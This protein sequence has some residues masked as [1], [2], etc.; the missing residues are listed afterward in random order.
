MQ[1]RILIH[2]DSSHCNAKEAYFVQSH[3]KREA[4]EG[5]SKLEQLE[6]LHYEIPPTATWIPI[7]AI[8]VRSQG[9]TRQSENY[10]FEKNAK[11]SNFEIWQKKN[12]ICDTPSEADW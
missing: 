10:K 11:N 4:I 9:K 3:Y 7:L 12:F 6:R 8:H 1:I 2:T 5:I